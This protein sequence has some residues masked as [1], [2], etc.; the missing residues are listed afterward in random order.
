[1]PLPP[2][3]LRVIALLVAMVMCFVAIGVRLFDL[4]ARDRTH[5]ASLGLGQR[6]STVAIPAERGNIFDSTGKILAVS[7]PQ[8]TITADPRVIK[9]PPRYA[10][11]LVPALAAG[12]VQIDQNA[13]QARLSD[14]ASAFAYVAR[15]V[16]DA[17]AAAVRKLDLVGIS[18]TPESKRFYPSGSLAGPVIGFVGTDNNG[19]GGLE[20]RYDKAMEGHAG[21]VQVERDPQGNDIPG[22]ERQVHPA[23]R[24][25]DLVLTMDQA[26]QWNTEQALVQGVTAANAKGGTAIVVDVQTGDVLAMASVDGAT[27]DHPVQVASAKENNRPVT[28]IYEPGSTNKVIT[29][30]GAIQEGLVS[31]D[32]VLQNVGQTKQVGDTLYKDVDD[33]PSAMSVTDILAQ[34]SNVG[35]IDIA[36]MLGARRFSSYV[37]AFGFGKLTGIGLPGE[38]SGSTLPLSQYNDT[39][40]ASI[41]IGYS[42]AVTALQMLDVYTTIA[43]GGVAR[44]PRLVQ[45][46]VDADG[47]RHDVP[48]APTHTVVSAATARA[49]TGMLEQVVSNGTGMKAAI[50]HYPVAGKT[51]TALKVPY[52]THET[53][54]SFA[55]FAPAGAPRLS[56]IVVMDAPQGSEFG[57]DAAAPVFKQIMQFALTYERVPTAS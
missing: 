57:G 11:E 13:L 44:P 15:Q 46:T 53:N 30:S 49:V 51:G 5:L 45:A 33:H 34:S 31:P 10:A 42:V 48:L 1:V 27:N 52:D 39:S 25:E 56:A 41:P 20:Y 47:V 2:V 55:G 9:D 8:T 32:T 29:M 37:D 3:R 38:S 14:R 36:A 18:F 4:Q 40:M 23:K 17:T 21:T 50:E 16:D 28:D 6:V 35:T 43:N 12:G 26:L 24:G 22:G 7:V 54:A 19:L